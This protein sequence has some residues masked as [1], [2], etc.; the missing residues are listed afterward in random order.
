MDEVELLKALQAVAKGGFSVQLP[1][2]GTG[3]TGAS[4][5][6]STRW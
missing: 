4:P 6:P 5:M 2:T 3:S 1:L